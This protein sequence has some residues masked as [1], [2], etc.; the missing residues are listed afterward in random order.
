MPTLT[1]NTEAGPN[2]ADHAPQGLIG[3]PLDRVDGPLKTSG[4]ATYAFEFQ[5]ERAPAYGQLV[6]ATIAK[7]KVLGIDTAAAL[8]LPGVIAVID[9]GAHMTQDASNQG[10]GPGTTGTDQVGHY[11]QPLLL[12]VG[13]TAEAAREGAIA[14]RIDYAPA[15][16]G[17]FVLADHAA[18][19]GQPAFPFFNVANQKAGDFDGAFAA[20]P[21][22]IDV[23]YTTPPHIHAAMEP[24]AAL[25]EW[26]DGKLTVH[27]S[28]QMIAGVKA[29]LVK[30]LGVKSDEV[31]ML[32]PYVGGGFGSKLGL[33]PETITAAIAARVL[34]R[35]V[36]VAMT[37]QEQFHITG[38]RSDSIQH[39][40]L[41]AT[42]EGQAH[43]DRA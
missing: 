9:C 20:A 5:P 13:E 14:V 34:D 39:I 22:T 37:R 36:K 42:A 41:G 19:A 17:R 43:R 6:T 25:A 7:G 15:A 24:H 18:E 8:V 4:R 21:V 1:M 40:R 10:K 28:Y 11:G 23:T 3:A 32:S 2:R 27:A 38:R 16:D 33:N 29:Q 31:R 30:Q 26:N 35:P 12:V